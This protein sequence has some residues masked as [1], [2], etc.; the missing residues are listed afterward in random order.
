M[1]CFRCQGKLY[2]KPLVCGKKFCPIY[3]KVNLFK[4]QKL[5]KKDFMATAPGVFVGRY[6]YPDINVGI[7]SP[8]EQVKEAEMYESP[9][10]WVSRNLNIPEIVDFRSVLINSKFKTNIKQKTQMLNMS[11]EVAMASRPVDLEFNLIKKPFYFYKTSN[12]ESPMGATASLKKVFITENIKIDRRVDYIVND[13]DLKSV[14]GLKDLFDRG[15]DENFLTKLLSVGNLGL[16]KDRKLVPTRWSITAVDDTLGKKMIE[17]IKDYKESDFKLFFGGTFG[18]YYLVMF[19][20]R[21]WSYELF[22]MYMPKGL[23]NPS[24]KIEVMTD[25]EFYDGRKKYAENCVGGYYACRL[26]ILEKLRDMKRQAMVVTLRFITDEYT[27]PLGVWVCRESTRKA[28]QN[29]LDFD[30]KEEMVKFAGALVMDKLGFDITKTM[31]QSKLYAYMNTQ[32]TLF[33]F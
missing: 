2:Q 15:Y 27:T 6:S 33:E 9:K 7:I 5:T 4:S 13:V 25:H 29:S 28:L 23:L 31:K 17:E 12:I 8:P 20:P 16:K 3:S 26:S 22:E 11:Q 1:E 10:E 14:Y 21:V 24:E 18:N 19:F 30:S 32:K